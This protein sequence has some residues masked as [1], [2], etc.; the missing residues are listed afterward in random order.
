MG[1]KNIWKNDCT[2]VFSLEDI[3]IVAE[4]MDKEGGTFN[5]VYLSEKFNHRTREL[6]QRMQKTVEDAID[7]GYSE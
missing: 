7:E 3:R 4:F 1:V 2:F 6:E 5:D